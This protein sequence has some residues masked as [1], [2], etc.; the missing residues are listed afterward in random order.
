MANNR[1]HQGV[2]FSKPRVIETYQM[3]EKRLEDEF[4]D[5]FLTDAACMATAEYYFSPPDEDEIEMYA[6][7]IKMRVE[8]YYADL[9]W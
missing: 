7:F 9:L 2:E 1:M 5:E 4:E 6:T 8:E 3:F